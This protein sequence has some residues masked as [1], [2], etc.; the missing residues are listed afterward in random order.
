MYFFYWICVSGCVGGL[1]VFSGVIW[2][3]SAIKPGN[4][5]LMA[6]RKI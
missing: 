3:S 4:W 5:M 6:V 2:S 1:G